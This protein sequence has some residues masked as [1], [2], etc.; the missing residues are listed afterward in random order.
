MSVDWTNKTIK[1]IP[2][3]SRP[4]TIKNIVSV[5]LILEDTSMGGMRTE[6]IDLSGSVKDK[7]RQYKEA[8]GKDWVGLDGAV[9]TT[10]ADA[11]ERG[12][13][14]QAEIAPLAKN[15]FTEKA[16]KKID[17]LTREAQKYLAE[18]KEA[19]KKAQVRETS[20][21]PTA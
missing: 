20:E 3:D 21:A 14:I 16:Q 17:A 10:Y 6:H 7:L 18:N 5:L 11:P 9:I 15:P 13:A 19:K 1:V 8:T 4:E 2:A 12:A